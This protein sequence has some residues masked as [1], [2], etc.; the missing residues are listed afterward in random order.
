MPYEPE[1]G[2]YDG[3]SPRRSGRSG[4]VLRRSRSACGRILAPSTFLSR[5]GPSCAGRSTAGCS[6]RGRGF[7][8][9]PAWKP[10]CEPA[11]DASRLRGHLLPPPPRPGGAARRNGGRARPGGAVRPG[12]V[13][14][15]FQLPGPP[16][17]GRDRGLG[18]AWDTMGDASGSLFVAGLH[19][20]RGAAVPA[21]GRRGGFRGVFAPGPGFADKQ[22]FGGPDTRWSVWESGTAT[23]IF[24][25]VSTS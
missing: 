23:G 14:R 10:G 20:R 1:P 11:P 7:A 22:V 17:R 18:R 9:V 5:G 3:A 24:S 12:A 19:R 13:C 21:R 25:R 8:Q 2:R 15:D 4:L 6:I 16:R